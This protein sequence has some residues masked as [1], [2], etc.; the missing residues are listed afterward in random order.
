MTSTS[1]SEPRLVLPFEDRAAAGKILAAALRSVLPND[2]VIVGLARGGVVVAAEVAKALG[3]ELDVVAVRKV[4]APWQ[5]EYAL[6]AVAPGDGV[7]IRDRAGLS[8]E[9][10][11][12]L[13]AAAQELAEKRDRAF[14]A[15]V[16]PVDL[17]GRPCALVD[18]GLATGATMVAAI[19]WAKSR[20][21][22]PVFTAVPVGAKSSRGTIE[23]ESAA[24]ICPHLV[25]EFWAV[26]FWYERFEQVDDAEVIR[27]LLTARVP[28]S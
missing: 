7:V 1:G 5:P 20:H 13:V 6:G 12:R 16:P 14:H 17:A 28:P 3:A 18:D 2:T 22:A 24:L 27:L 9:S 8:E 21:A 26:G 23:A 10:V 4:G 15:A 11:A 25:D 19:R